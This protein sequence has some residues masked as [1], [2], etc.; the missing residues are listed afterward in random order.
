VA[1][2]AV[3]VPIVGLAHDE[4][5]RRVDMVRALARPETTVEF[6]VVPD[7]PPS[8]ESIVEEELAAAA[9]LRLLGSIGPRPADAVIVWCAGDPGVLAARE[10][11]DCPVV[12]PG[13]SAIRLASLLAYRFGVLTPLPAETTAAALLVDRI[14]L[15]GRFVGSAAIGISV[16]DMRHDLDRTTARITSAGGRLI[17]Q[18]AQALVLGC[19]GM[20]G[21]AKTVEERLGIPVLDPAACAVHFAE[22]LMRGGYTFSRATY[23]RPPKPVFVG[24]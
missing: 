15:T 22:L 4:L 10:L 16:L 1:T 8:I 24:R 5:Q 20:F 11:L 9:V 2:L 19:M 17:D 3:V 12:G 6:R 18:G 23:A 14:G 7:G 21:L 13:E